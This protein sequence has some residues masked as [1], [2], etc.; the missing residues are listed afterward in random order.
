LAL[1]AV[2]FAPI[3]ATLVD[4]SMVDPVQLWICD[5][6][7]SAGDSLATLTLSNFDLS[8]SSVPATLQ[9]SIDNNMNWLNAVP[10]INISG[11]WRHDKL[12]RLPGHSH[13][14]CRQH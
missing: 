14:D 9:Y 3:F 8:S 5:E 7:G 10:V 11:E 12:G 4:A 13:R 1:I 6:P 2:L